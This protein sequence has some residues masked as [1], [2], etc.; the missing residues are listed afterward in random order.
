MPQHCISA[1][2]LIPG[3]ADRVYGIIA[4]YKEG[5][6]RILPKPYFVSLK[7]EKGGI[8]EGTIISC[9]MKLMGKTRSFRAIISEPEPGR[10]LVESDLDNRAVTTFIVEPRESNRQSFVTISTEIE[11]RKGILG[12]LERKL[13]TRLL[14]PIY[15]KELKQLAR[16]VGESG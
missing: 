1:S 8:G 14:Q 11:T 10:V 15:E 5:H 9:Q 12:L 6:P 2:A 3:P 7:V 16:V 4:D 13:M